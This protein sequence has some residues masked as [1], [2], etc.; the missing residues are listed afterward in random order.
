MP[1]PLLDE[2]RDAYRGGELVLFVGP[3]LT[4]AAGLPDEAALARQAVARLR[5]RGAPDDQVAEIEELL[6]RR[7]PRAALLAAREAL[8]AA[9]FDGMIEKA[10]DLGDRPLPPLALAIAALLPGL[11]AVLGVGLDRTLDRALA[12]AWDVLARPTGDLLA[13]R[14]YLLKLHGTLPERDTWIFARPRHSAALFDSPELAAV[15]QSLYQRSALLCVGWGPDD[16]LDACFA[17]AR[18]RAVRAAHFAMLPWAKQ[19]PAQAARLAAAGV[20]LHALDSD[21]QLADRLRSIVAPP[22]AAPLAPNDPAPPRPAPSTAPV[23]VLACF[24]AEDAP[25]F[26]R[27]DAHLSALKAQRAVD[28]WHPGLVRAGED[29]A[30][31]IE[32]RLAGAQIVL[33][34]MSASLLASDEGA[35]QIERALARQREGALTIVPVRLRACDWEGTGVEQ[36][37]ALPPDGS[38]VAGDDEDHALL[39]VARGLRAVVSTLRR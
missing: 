25:L 32:A 28:L 15:F 22:M 9:D 34:L 31:Q 29:R 24:A 2:L 14:R 20:R 30:Q 12:G 4:I 3:G 17:F 21:D 38:T 36:L 18:G 7:G 27:L 16:G 35:R 5:G 1:D 11:R 13:R 23:P 6:A 19:R 33:L 37:P 8:G 39:A 10:L 26:A